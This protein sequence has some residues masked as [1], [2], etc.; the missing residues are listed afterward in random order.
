MADFNLAV[1]K[2]LEKEGVFSNHPKDTGGKTKYGI[3]ERRFRQALALGVIQGVERIEDL[4]IAQAMEIYRRFEWATLWLDQVD[5]QEIAEEVF[6]T[7]VNCGMGIASRILQ[8][9]LR[10]YDRKVLVDGVVGPMTIL[11]V[12]LMSRT[13]HRTALLR[14]LNILQGHRYFS[15]AME[16]PDQY[17]WAYDGWVN[18]RVK[19]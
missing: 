16:D 10:V 7:A 3:T 19:L 5:D 17:L 6:D 11:A 2:V 9:A 4:T 12:N 14:T 1:K 8:A 13:K 18:N 15:L